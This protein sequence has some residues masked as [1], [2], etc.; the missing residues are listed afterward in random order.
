MNVEVDA[1]DRYWALVPRAFLDGAYGEAAG[2]VEGTL[3]RYLSVRPE[4][5]AEERAA[6]RS[7]LERAVR[8]LLP[9]AAFGLLFLP[10]AAPTAALVHVEIGAPG[11]GSED[12][13]A[14]LL[15][16]VP[17]GRAPEI[18]TVDVPAIGRGV[19]ARFIS[20]QAEPGAAAVAGIGY[21]ISGE[22]CAV[23]VTSAPMTTTMVGLIDQPLRHVIETLRVGV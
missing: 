20:G 14:S 5:D 23:R 2:W 18:E 6:M 22:R 21:L 7:I 11:T 19:S 8:E 12:L 4:A 3:A 16:G 15:D 1:D 17:L 13:V 10:L 9:D